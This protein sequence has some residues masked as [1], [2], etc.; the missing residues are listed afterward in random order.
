[1]VLA[2][3]LA[4][5]SALLELHSDNCGCQLDRH[6]EMESGNEIKSDTEGGLVCAHPH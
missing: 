5:T 2:S 1:M 3:V 4:E 6:E